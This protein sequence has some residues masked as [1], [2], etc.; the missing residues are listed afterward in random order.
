[1]FEEAF[2]S[3]QTEMV[4]IASEY[5]SGQAEGIY[6]YFSFL[7]GIGHVDTFFVKDGKTYYRHLPGIDTSL[8][9]QNALLRSF[10][11]ALNSIRMA[12]KKYERQLPKEGFLHYEVSG[13]HDA[14]YSY[15]DI[16]EGV[17]PPW[18][19]RLET[20]RQAVQTELDTRS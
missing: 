17:Y 14:R 1:M 5:S 20:W 12:C 15:E 6:V 10:L 4:R 16:P 3:A 8:A 9:R 2:S 7:G 13:S 11:D 18:D 19:E